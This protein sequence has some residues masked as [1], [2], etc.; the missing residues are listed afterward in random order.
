M[1]AVCTGEATALL[2]KFVSTFI[3]TFGRR[4]SVSLMNSYLVA[5]L[6]SG[7]A[8]LYVRMEWTFVE[9]TAICLFRTQKPD[10]S[11]SDFSDAAPRARRRTILRLCLCY[12]GALSRAVRLDYMF[13]ATYKLVPEIYT[14]LALSRLLS[15]C[16]Y[17][18]LC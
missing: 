14:T 9:R 5:L 17:H 1:V 8:S 3:S 6:G 12:A 18:V 16:P 15:S 11:C 7:L 4:P 10:Y 2:G 13:T